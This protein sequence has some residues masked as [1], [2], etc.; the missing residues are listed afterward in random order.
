MGLIEERG[1]CNSARLRASRRHCR[2]ALISTATTFA[3]DG[4]QFRSRRK[5]STK[6]AFYRR[7][8][9]GVLRGADTA[10]LRKQLRH[11]G[12]RVTLKFVELDGETFLAPLK[13]LVEAF[14]LASVS[15]DTFRRDPLYCRRYSLALDVRVAIPSHL[16]ECV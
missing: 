15:T 3:I 1:R 8:A 12:T 6:V 7:H 9:Q 14:D 4:T 16:A 11:G 5:A 10:P 2:A 13:G